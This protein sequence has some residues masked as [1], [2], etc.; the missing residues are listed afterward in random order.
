MGG[1]VEGTTIRDRGQRLRAIGHEMASRFRRSQVGTVRR[2]LTVD[3]GLAAVTDNYL[4]VRLDQ[5][6]PR[7]QWIEAR[8]D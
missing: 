8:I 2:A 5:Q 7:N 3:D 6:F 4:K 1:K